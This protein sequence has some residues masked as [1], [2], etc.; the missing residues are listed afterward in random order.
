[1]AD[2]PE[3]KLPNYLAFAVFA[4]TAGWLILNWF[5]RFHHPPVGTYIGIFAFVAGIVTIWPPQNRWAKAAWVLVFGAF[6]ALELSTL[7]QQRAEDSDTEQANTKAED[8]RF[9][10]LL[11]TEHESFGK[12][13]EQNQKQ[14]DATMKKSNKIVE[15]NRATIAG[16]QESINTVTGGD[17]FAG[18]QPVATGNNYHL[19]FTLVPGGKYP[20]HALTVRGFARNTYPA[21]AEHVTA[22]MQRGEQTVTIGD[23]PAPI[24]DKEFSVAPDTNAIDCHAMFV[25]TNGYWN[26]MIQLRLVNGTWKRAIKIVRG[27]ANGPAGKVLVEHGDDG[28]PKEPDGSIKWFMTLQ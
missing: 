9:A 7:Y 12:V 1:M 15:L 20:L 28:Y 5:E 3:S 6:L 24:A 10:G 8:D 27:S 17:S 19:V 13:L 4:I 22:D 26:Q 11:N 14:F 21:T 25:A 2:S 23:L 18:L 16:V